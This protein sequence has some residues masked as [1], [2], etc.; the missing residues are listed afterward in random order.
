MNKK[1]VMTII[2]A[3]GLATA[4]VVVVWLLVSGKLI[5]SWAG[6]AGSV[7]TA[8][9]VCGEGI[10][11]DYNAAVRLSLA[12]GRPDKLKVVAD[13]VV[14]K[15]DIELDPNCQ[16]I[17]FNYYIDSAQYDKARQCLS[18][19]KHLA[20]EGKFSTTELEMVQSISAMQLLLNSTDVK[21]E[22]G[23]G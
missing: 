22:T 13:K 5:M 16:A 17:L 3:V 21:Q 11:D 2:G 10:I 14:D 9:R 8:P 20:D 12:D 6:S 23:K 18:V 4:V 7:S 15:P 19:A 1:K